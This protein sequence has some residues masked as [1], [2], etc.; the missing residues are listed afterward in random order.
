MKCTKVKSKL[1]AYRLK[2]GSSMISNAKVV[3]NWKKSLPDSSVAVA[4]DMP[5]PES[6]NW[7]SVDILR[8]N[9]YGQAFKLSS[10]SEDEIDCDS[11]CTPSL[12]LF[13]LDID[14]EGICIDVPVKPGCFHNRKAVP[15]NIEDLFSTTSSD[16]EDME[17]AAVTCSPNQGNIVNAVGKNTF[18]LPPISRCD[19][20][21]TFLD[22]VDFFWNTCCGYS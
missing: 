21:S 1:S 4:K 13:S 5:S 20:A 18:L 16:A 15:V 9:K 12:T 8:K 22:I 14:S 19:E 3:H 11:R 10:D 7:F 2:K 17:I 6:A